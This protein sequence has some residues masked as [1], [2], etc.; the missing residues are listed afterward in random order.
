M[1]YTSLLKA[2]AKFNVD[3]IFIDQI[4]KNLKQVAEI[5]VYI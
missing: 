3:V 4:V 1:I 2:Y 5:G